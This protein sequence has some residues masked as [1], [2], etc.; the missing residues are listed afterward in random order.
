[1]PSS[2][3]TPVPTRVPPLPPAHWRPK[4]SHEANPST[5]PIPAFA[6]GRSDTTQ[7]PTLAP[8]PPSTHCRSAGMSCPTAC[9]LRI[10]RPLCD[11]SPVPRLTNVNRRSFVRRSSH[12]TVHPLSTPRNRFSPTE[13]ARPSFPNSFV[14]YP[15]QLLDPRSHHSQKLI[16]RSRCLQP[17]T[18]P[19]R[20]TERESFLRAASV[21]LWRHPSACPA[22]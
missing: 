6:A 12:G 9:P 10:V 22:T 15:R 11:R 20:G 19:D 13:A 2:D 16:Q 5:P 18:R 14:S 8:P 4:V 3:P 7:V 1:M 21:P 17:T